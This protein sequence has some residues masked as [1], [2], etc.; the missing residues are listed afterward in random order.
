MSSLAKVTAVGSRGC[1]DQG[2]RVG[3]GMRAELQFH[4]MK[5]EKQWLVIL[6]IQFRG[7]K[8]IYMLLKHPTSLSRILSPF[9][10]ETST[11]SLFPRHW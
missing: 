7:I 8:Y 6:S 10:I 2:E 5:E 3:H 4:K 11:P 9:E 1:Q